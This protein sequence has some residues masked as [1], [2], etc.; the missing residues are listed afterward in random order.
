MLNAGVSYALSPTPIHTGDTFTLDIRA[1]NVFDMAGWQFNIAF[2]RNALDAINVI[3]GVFLKQNGA[4]TL[5]QGG[6]INNGAGKIT[7]LKAVRLAPSGVSGSGTLVQVSFKAK[8]GGDTEV[9]LQNFQ[10]ANIT[11]D[12]IPAGPH[13]ITI[14]I[15]GQLAAGDVNRDGQVTVADLILVTAQLGKRVPAGTAEDVNGDGIVNMLDL[16]VVAQAI[17]S[18]AAP[19][20]VGRNIDA[21]M[22]EAWITQARLEDDGSLPFKQGIENL[23]KLL[24]S[25]IPKRTALL[26]NYPNPFN[27]ETWIPYHLAEAA[28]VT[29]TIYSTEGRSVHQLDLGYQRAGYYLTRGQAAYWD[30]RN[31]LG[32]PVGSGL[33]FYTLTTGDFTATRRMLILK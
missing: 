24:A 9:V 22:V 13:E 5:F 1:E 18:P 19:V 30:G 25:L 15:E 8:R 16:L 33:Y 4:S 12:S 23:Q 29:L 26:P 20:A 6:S 31:R 3:E 32:E 21:A 14:S 7:G 10:F 27:P 2:D 17:D 11:G 28:D